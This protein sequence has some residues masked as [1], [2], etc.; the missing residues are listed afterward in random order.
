LYVF[1][2]AIEQGHIG[3][4]IAGLLNSAVAAY[5]YLRLITLLYMSKPEGTPE[6][7]QPL[8]YQ[9]ALVVASVLILAIGIF[10]EPLLRILTLSVP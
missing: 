3:L 7:A 10:P 5:Y 9:T 4:A 8:A 2:A 1:S 6:I